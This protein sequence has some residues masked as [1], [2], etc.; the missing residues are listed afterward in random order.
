M[1][2]TPFQVQMP[3]IQFDFF[4]S[5]FVMNINYTVLIMLTNNL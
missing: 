3:M 2:I 5:E 1:G 4:L